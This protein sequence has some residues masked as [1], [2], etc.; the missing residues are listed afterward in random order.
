MHV[1]KN[2]VYARPWDSLMNFDNLIVDG[3]VQ[4]RSRWI[5]L[6]K[7]T[8]ARL[9]QGKNLLILKPGDRVYINK[10]EAKTEAKDDLLKISI[11]SCDPLDV[12]DGA[13]QKRYVATLSF[14]M[15]KNS[16]AGSGPD[17]VEQM[18]KAIL[19]PE[20]MEAGRNPNSVASAPGTKPRPAAPAAHA[21]AAFTQ[22]ISMGQTINQVVAI[23]GQPQQI[24]DLGAKEDLLVFRFQDH[25]CERESK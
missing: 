12:D 6:T 17:P 5:E 10:I 14:K 9:G 11:L 18:V 13:S 4:Q 8:E 24:V 3:A 20:A 2:G 15:N 23:M 16:L 7:T 25:I 21:P 19:A 22:S 1:L